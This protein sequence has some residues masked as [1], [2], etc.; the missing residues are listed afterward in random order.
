MEISVHLN[1]E[2]YIAYNIFYNFH[3]KT[4]KKGILL[5]RL[6]ALILS[7]VLWIAF[8]IVKVQPGI[9]AAEGVALLILSVLWFFFYPQRAKSA[10]KRRVENIGKEG[11]LPYEEYSVL[12]LGDTDIQSISE[13]EHKKIPYKNVQCLW[14]DE[15][16]DYI[17]VGALEAFIVPMRCLNEGEERQLVKLL[18]EKGITIMTV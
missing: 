17:Q 18:K 9:V 3:S 5:G 7:V 4:G 8:F 15:E 14:R 1:I 16:Y 10:I 12:K 6:L 2:D 11:K 13:T